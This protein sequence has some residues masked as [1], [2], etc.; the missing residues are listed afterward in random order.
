MTV[1][2][3]AVL[4]M[5]TALVRFDEKKMMVCD[6]LI[7]MRNLNGI[8]WAMCIFIIFLSNQCIYIY[9]CIFPPN[10]MVRAGAGL[11][12]EDCLRLRR[13]ESVGDVITS[14]LPSTQFFH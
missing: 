9:F 12:R 1:T 5:A 11:V 14:Q 8:G 2:L 6:S 7:F 13:E 4:D 3:D 10:V